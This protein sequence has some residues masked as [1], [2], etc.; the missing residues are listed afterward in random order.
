M[1]MI[2]P[3]I[4]SPQIILTM[5]ADFANGFFHNCTLTVTQDNRV[6]LHVFPHQLF[7]FWACW[8]TTPS[9]NIQPVSINGGSR[10]AIKPGSEAP[11]S[12]HIGERQLVTV[13]LRSLHFL[14][15]P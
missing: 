12:D 3:Y 1:E 6:L 14:P 7:E 8:S 13:E 4:A 11:N 15:R 5:I 10:I 2:R 9:V